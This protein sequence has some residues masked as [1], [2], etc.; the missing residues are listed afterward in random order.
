MTE[1]RTSSRRSY[2]KGFYDGL[3]A[4]GVKAIGET[5]NKKKFSELYDGMT[6][7]PRDVYESVPIKTS[8]SIG[9]IMD[10]MN[11]RG[12]AQTKTIVE[13]CLTMMIKN[14][15]VKQQKT[16]FYIREQVR[17]ADVQPV[18]TEKPINSKSNNSPI[19]LLN[20]LAEKARH[21][22]EELEY[23]AIEI[24]QEFQNSESKSEKLKQLQAL[25]KGIAD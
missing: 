25:L 10:D 19:Q 15:L 1:A 14:G 16:G 17:D 21:L 24:E 23:A 18:A 22:A 4:A 2:G 12:V 20:T 7:Q 6:S 3:R 11:R 5:M 9:Q 13:N 8:Y